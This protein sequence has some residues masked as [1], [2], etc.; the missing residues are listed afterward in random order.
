MLQTFT[1]ICQDQDTQ[2]ALNTPTHLKLFKN[3]D[4][5]LTKNK[6]ELKLY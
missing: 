6:N 2:E 5:P 1:M 4:K 3:G